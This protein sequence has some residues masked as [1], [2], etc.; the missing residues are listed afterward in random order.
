[1]DIKSLFPLSFIP[2]YNII[3]FF[4]HVFIYL[5]IGGVVGAVISAL[6]PG[7]ITLIFTL[8]VSLYCLA[9]IVLSFLNFTERI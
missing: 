1:M 2:K 7:I 9:G 5:V 4:I 6:L 8:P 3:Q